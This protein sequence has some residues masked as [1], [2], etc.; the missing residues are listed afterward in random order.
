MREHVIADILEN[1][2]IAVIRDVFG[3]D[4]LCLAE[5]LVSGGV[6]VMEC[7]FDQRDA[8]KRAKAA[9]TIALLRREMSGAARIGAGTVTVPALVSRAADSGAEFIVSPNTSEAVIRETL[10]AGLVSVPGALTPTE[11]QFAHECGADFVK[12]FPAGQMGPAYFKAVCQPL[13]DCRL[14][15]FGGVSPENARDYLAAGCEG[16][17]VSGCLFSGEMIRAGQWAEITR[18]AEKMSAAVRRK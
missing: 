12:V 16:V 11:I 15:A 9:E 8:E 7:A 1:R 18:R 6:R 14:L 3:G 4:C 2:V 17:G 5:A 10:T 13:N